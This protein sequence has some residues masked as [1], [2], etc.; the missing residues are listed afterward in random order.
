MT[1]SRRAAVV[2][3]ALLAAL[4]FSV[5]AQKLGSLH[6]FD[7]DER[8]WL[9]TGTSLIQKGTPA[10]W[11]IFWDKYPH[12]ENMPFGGVNHLVVE[13][14]LDHPPLFAL[15]VGAWAALTGNNG[16]KPLN[17]AVL[18]LPMVL[19]ALATI[20]VTWLFLRRLCGPPL[21]SFTLLA[22]SFFPA[23]IIASRFV[24]AE[25]AIA[26][27]LMLCLYAFLIVDREAEENPK[28]AALAKYIIVAVCGL[29]ILLKLSAIVIPATIGLLSLLRK[30][31]PLF[32]SVVAATLVSVLLFVGYGA[33]YDWGIF[34]SVMA[35]HGSR[36]QSF[37][38]FWSIVTQL[39]LGYFPL[40][41]PSVIIGFVG[42]FTLLA[43][44]VIPWEKRLYIFAPLLNFSLLFLFIA[45]VESYG[46]Y[47]Y[48]LFPLL[49]VG[50]GHVL[51]ELYRGKAAYYVL[52]L[53]AVAVML[54]QSR[55]V[56]SQFQRRAWV[57]LLY[58]V[59]A[60]AILLRHY[61]KRINFLP[62]TFGI[63]LVMLFSL[64]L[65]WVHS[66]LAV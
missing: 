3:L 31:R 47:K 51:T 36:P 56:E 29:A 26:F 63:A 11:T 2:L 8:V 14:F 44:S 16:P 41:D 20:G 54:E 33:Y 60:A 35:G 66:L 58:G 24:V 15:G 21:S 23:H 4:A 37:W 1:S 64:E 42:L 65:I 32:K 43:D 52:L 39:D 48:V 12:R 22:F 45:P 46:W 59:V 6:P 13:P 19:L 10:S 9:L 27:L 30:N 38:H 53:P 49:A 5:R 18:R 50:L 25:N 17:W 62:V 28:R 40:R 61:T 34:K 57:L 55:L 7:L